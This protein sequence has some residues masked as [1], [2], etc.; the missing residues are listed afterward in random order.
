MP[1]YKYNINGN[2]F[3]SKKAVIEY[4]KET[5]LC[6][7][8]D[9]EFLDDTHLQFMVELLRHHPYSDQK[10][11]V[12]V[13]KMWI[14]CNVPYETK[15]FWLQRYDK[16]TTDFSFYHCVSPPSSLR[17]VKSACR[18][19]IAPIIIDFRKEF[20]SQRG[21]SVK[22]PVS[23]DDMS[24]YT[25]HVDHVFPNTFDNIVNEFI[26]NCGIEVEKIPLMEHSD[27]KVGNWFADKT[28]EKKWIDFHNKRA[29]LRV[30]SS[31]ANLSLRSYQD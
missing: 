22:C 14:Q 3:K 8:R 12:G 30:I 9:F 17:D 24:L 27:G 6:K 18:R 15:G 5:I 23:G 4:V 7:Y 2:D 26:Q 29:E 11:G 21:S 16:T 1:R 13:E 25:S 19:A 20:F 28:F 31:Q 10:I